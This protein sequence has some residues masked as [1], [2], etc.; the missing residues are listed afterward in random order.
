MKDLKILHYELGGHKY[1][2]KYYKKKGINTIYFLLDDIFDVIKYANNDRNK[3]YREIFEKLINK[4]NEKGIICIKDL[5]TYIDNEGG[6][7]VGR[8]MSETLTPFISL[9]TLLN[10]PE[11]YIEVCVSLARFNLFKEFLEEKFK[12]EKMIE[13]L[14]EI[15]KNLNDVLPPIGMYRPLDKTSDEIIEEGEKL[16][17]EMRKGNENEK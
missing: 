6:L 16:I 14:I 17:K 5:F 3:E 10:L 1:E 8:S 12:K 9:L 7:V 4:L 11:K 15:P 13:E 2:I